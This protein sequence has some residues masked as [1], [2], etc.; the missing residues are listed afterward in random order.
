MNKLNMLLILPTTPFFSAASENLVRNGG[1]ELGAAAD[2]APLEWTLYRSA[3]AEG[4]AKLSDRFGTES[5]SCV[6]IWKSNDSAGSVGLKQNVKLEPDSKYIFY[7]KGARNARKRWHYVQLRLLP[8]KKVIFHERLSY[9]EKG[10]PTVLSKLEP[11]HFRT[12]RNKNVSLDI[13]FGVWGRRDNDET[14]IGEIWVDEIILRKEEAKSMELK[15]VAL[16]YFSDDVVS[17]KLFVNLSGASSNMKIQLDI[18][19]E[20]GK[21]HA[22]KT[23]EAQKGENDFSINLI[24]APPGKLAAYGKSSRIDKCNIIRHD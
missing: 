8:E 4:G 19:G 5:R 16:Y 3:K 13:S 17:G 2:G 15:G 20:D 21:R 14:S 23:F 9:S 1:F 24:S 11:F 10:K 22:G 18:F 6:R 12:G 7:L